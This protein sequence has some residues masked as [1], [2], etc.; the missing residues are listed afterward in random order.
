MLTGRRTAGEAKLYR[1]SF[2]IDYK[3]N[4]CK[5]LPRLLCQ[6]AGL[7]AMLEERKRERERERERERGTHGGVLQ[8]KC[9]V[10]CHLQDCGENRK[11]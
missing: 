7:S 2:H 4:F 11:A 5:V 6:L 1:N 8:M 9:A 10:Q 3:I